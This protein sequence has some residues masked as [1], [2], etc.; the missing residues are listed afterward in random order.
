[1][2]PC[3]RHGTLA[4]ATAAATLAPASLLA[5]TSGT[6]Q[7]EIIGTSPLAGLGVDRQLLP[8]ASQTVRRGA[9]DQAQADNMTDH[10]ARRLPGMQVNDIQGSPFQADLSYRGYRAS[11]LLGASQGLSVY[12]DGVRINEPF[13]DVVNW[14]MVPEFAL[15]SLTVLPGANPSFGLNTLGGAIVLETVDGRSAEGLRAEAGFGSHGR[16]RAELGLGQRH[17]DGWHSYVGGTVFDENATT[18]PANRPWCWPGWAAARAAPTG[19]LGCWP[20]APPW[21]ATACCPV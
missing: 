4:L 6:Q 12:L 10:L 15:Q 16:K 5:Q 18:R 7:V 13:G 17:A 20:A 1:M 11:G 19:A 8:Y 3:L 2:F 14:D 9:L 21:W